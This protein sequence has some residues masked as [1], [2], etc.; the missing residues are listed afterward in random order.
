MNKEKTAHTKVLFTWSGGKDSALALYELQK[1]NRYDVR[2]LLTTVTEDYGRVSMHGVRETLL[3][4]QAQSLGIPLEK[5]YIT[6]KGS[7][8]EYE[9]C[10]RRMFVSFKRREVL[11][12]AYG[13]ILLE[14]LRMHREKKLEEL[15]MKAL[16]PLWAADTSTLGRG[17]IDLGFRAVVVCVDSEKLDGSFCGREYDEGFLRDLPRTVDPCGE[18]GE[19]HTFVYDGPNFGK[20]VTI[21]TGEVVLRDSRFYF[22][23]LIP[24]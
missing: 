20:K 14:D 21:D 16:F 4:L 13:D 5:V 12:V 18:N 8:E 11:T 24:R 9:A 23:D 3:E 17:F 1:T 22:Y 15:S 2:A 6:K 19:F 7:S 10:M